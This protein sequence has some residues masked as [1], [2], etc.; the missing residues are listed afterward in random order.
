M[1]TFNVGDFLTADA[2]NLV[3][4]PPTCRLSQA[5]TQNLTNATDTALTFGVGSEEWDSHGFHDEVTNNTRITPTVSGVYLWIFSVMVAA[6]AN[7]NSLR[8]SLY[9]NGSPVN[10]RIQIYHDA[11]NAIKGTLN[12]ILAEANGTT[13]YFELYASQTSTATLAT[14]GPSYNPIFSCVRQGPLIASY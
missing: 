1:S 7:A 10:G 8:C 3:A 5:T 14:N 9:R 4:Q 12:C 6:S 2:L 13:D 11:S